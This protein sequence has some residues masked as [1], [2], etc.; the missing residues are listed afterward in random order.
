MA[1]LTRVETPTLPLRQRKKEKT[2]RLLLEAADRMFREKGYDKVTLEEICDAAEMS[3]RTFF[4]YFRSKR[5]L[6]LFRQHRNSE[7]IRD[8]L[9]A[10]ENRDEP[11]RWVR[12]V[13]SA[14]AK[15]LEDDDKAADWLHWV[16]DEQALV[17]GSLVI[18]LE[19]EAAIAK[20][21]A[22]RAGDT[23][24]ALFSARLLATMIVGGIRAEL[25][26]WLKAKRSYSFAD[27]CRA[28]VDHGAQAFPQ[29]GYA[30]PPSKG[31]P[32]RAAAK[33]PNTT[34]R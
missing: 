23:D 29:W 21:L 4:R 5:D 15:E 25:L 18:D 19:I 13:Y 31:A 8:G 3:T 28:V 27:S 14:I 12:E 34:R 20:A 2:A 9:D 30:T 16:T 7:M 32:R 24:E 17:A 1:T 22:R 11:L 10:E 26:R 33:S 6:A